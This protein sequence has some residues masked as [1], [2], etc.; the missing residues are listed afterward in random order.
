[1]DKQSYKL[2]MCTNQMTK[3][4]KIADIQYNAHDAPP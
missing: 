1:M 2:E 4:N 3:Y